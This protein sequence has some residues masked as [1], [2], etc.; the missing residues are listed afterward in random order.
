MYHQPHLVYW[1]YAH[2]AVTLYTNILCI[3]A[4]SCTTV[5]DSDYSLWYKQFLQTAVCLSLWILCIFFHQRLLLLSFLHLSAI[6]NL[7][8]SQPITS[9]NVPQTAKT[10]NCKLATLIHQ[11]FGAFYFYNHFVEWEVQ[12]IHCVCDCLCIFMITFKW[13]NL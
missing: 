6:R 13:N 2:R 11:M 12:S 10:I 7:F 5:V 4:L 1:V 9:A 3:L 8:I